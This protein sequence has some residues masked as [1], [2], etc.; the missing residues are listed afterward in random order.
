MLENVQIRATKLVD[1]MKNME[2]SERLK[3][4]NLPTLLYRRECGDLIHV[5]KHFNTYETSTISS[6]FKMNPRTSRK[7]R[8]Q[9]TWNRSKDGFHGVQTNSFY[10]RTASIWNSLPADVAEANNI[11]MFKNKLDEAWY[12]HPTKYTIDAQR[13]TNDLDRFVEAM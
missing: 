11:E 1:G 2:Y 6:N 9:L 8:Y 3:N 7:H 4:L 13:N 12:N 10:F 5:W